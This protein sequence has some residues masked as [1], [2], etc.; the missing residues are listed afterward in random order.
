[1]EEFQKK[2]LVYGHIINK[3]L[4]HKLGNGVSTKNADEIY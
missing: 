4:S 3:T 2:N 1:M